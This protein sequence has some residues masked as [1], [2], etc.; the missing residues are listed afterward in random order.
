METIKK[1]K[2][3][4][5]ID[6]KFQD[7]FQD[8]LKQVFFYMTDECQLRCKQ[9]LYKP[10][11]VFHMCKKEIPF[12]TLVMLMSDFR[13]LGATK[14]TFMGGEPSCY[15]DK[16]HKQFMA[17]IAKAKSL[18]YEYVRMDTNGQF[19][20]D[21]LRQPGMKNLDEISFSLD[22]HTSRIHDLL[23]GKG[24]FKKCVTN[25]KR[26]IELGYKV[27]VTGCVHRE[28]IKRD[29]DGNLQLDRFIKFVESLGVNTV[30]FHVLFKHGFPIDTWSGETDIKVEEWIKIFKELSKKV[31]NGE[32]KISV[33][34]PQHFVTRS[35]FDKNPPYYG[36][37]AAKLG[38]RVLVQPNG[39]IRICSGMLGSPYH[40]ANFYNGKIVWEES[41]TNELIDHKLEEFTPCTNQSKGMDCGKYLPLCFSFK[42][43]QNEF[44]WKKKLAWEKKT[45]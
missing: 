20:D 4:F 18:G 25:I 15:G 11:L 24:A 44:V 32:Y 6:K 38:E 17:L 14:L 10:N 1:K 13:T 31:D 37:C 5:D 33:R 8:R 45:K 41:G 27:D 34:I 28:L 39:E 12:E 35:E 19:E 3:N 40:V 2:F 7:Y 9:C 43:K 30:N 23:R 16:D 21:Y 36:Y 26:A 22:G 29:K 42:P